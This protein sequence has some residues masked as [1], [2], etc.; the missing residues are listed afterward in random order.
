MGSSP[1]LGMFV[2]NAS[3]TA[4]YCNPL[5]WRFINGLEVTSADK[6]G[7]GEKNL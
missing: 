1:A 2:I 6:K 3:H 5:R 4:E 7:T